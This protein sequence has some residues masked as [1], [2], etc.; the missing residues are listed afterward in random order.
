MT[1]RPDLDGTAHFIAKVISLYKDGKENCAHVNYFCR[2]QTQDK[3]PLKVKKLTTSS[4]LGCDTVLG[5]TEYTREL[6]LVKNSCEEV[7]LEDIVRTV[8]VSFW[9][10]DPAEWAEMGGT[11]EAVG[12]AP[13]SDSEHAF[14]FRMR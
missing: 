6:F 7:N 8:D 12:Q 2:G 14:Y 4:C 13:I 11:E 5:E 9:Q 10:V 3:S 1:I